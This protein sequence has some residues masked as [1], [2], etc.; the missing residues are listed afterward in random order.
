MAGRVY[1]SDGGDWILSSGGVKLRFATEGEAVQAMREQEYI[2]Q[3]RAANRAVWDGINALKALQREW[4]ALD[5]GTTL[6]DGAG[7]NAGIAADDVGAV[8][9]D[10]A[11]ALIVVLDA[12]HATNMSKLL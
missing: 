7:D 9:F 6:D 11:N 12:G 3:A 5:Y 8:V 4:A 2:T 1:Q 10:T